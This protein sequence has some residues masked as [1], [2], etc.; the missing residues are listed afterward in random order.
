AGSFFMP[1]V[2]DEVL[3]AFEHGDTRFPYVIG[4]TWNGV[5]LPPGAD[6]KD[7]KLVSKN[8]HMLRFLDASPDSGSLGAL[9]IE[10]AYG[11]RITMSDGKIVVQGKFIIEIEAPAIY[12]Q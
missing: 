8:G 4:F 5:D 3:V 6:V 1:N 9:V 11:N 10:D 12:L 2:N 7:R